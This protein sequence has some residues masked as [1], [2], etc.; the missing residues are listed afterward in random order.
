M[1]I[2]AEVTCSKSVLV[3]TCSS[4]LQCETVNNR[5]CHSL[6]ISN[7]LIMNKVAFEQYHSRIYHLNVHPKMIII[8]DGRMTVLKLAMVTIYGTFSSTRI[9]SF[10]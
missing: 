3:K 5:G 1:G 6:L 4:L 7:Y 2:N 9:N 8:T 10:G